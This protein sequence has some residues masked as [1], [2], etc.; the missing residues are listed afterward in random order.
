M[1]LRKDKYLDCKIN[2]P[3]KFTNRD[4][5]HIRIYVRKY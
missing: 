5:I 3:V 4:C 2:Y 1:K